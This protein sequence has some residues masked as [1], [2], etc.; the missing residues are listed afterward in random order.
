[1]ENS[2]DLDRIVLIGRTFKEYERMFLLEGLPPDA[3]RILDAARPA[4]LPTT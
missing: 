2:L 4:H 3:E 1:M